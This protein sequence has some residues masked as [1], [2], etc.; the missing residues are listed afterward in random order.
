MNKKGDLII[1]IK[2]YIK[3]KLMNKAF[4]LFNFI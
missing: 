1:L 3:K 4:Q 2:K